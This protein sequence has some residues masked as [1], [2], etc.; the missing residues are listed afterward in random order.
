[1]DKLCENKILTS[2]YKRNNLKNEKWWTEILEKIESQ[3]HCSLEK[4]MDLLA[5]V[6][7]FELYMSVL[8]IFHIRDK[9]PSDTD[10]TTKRKQLKCI[11]FADSNQ[12]NA[13]STRKSDLKM[14]LAT[15][16][17]V[18]AYTNFFNSP[19]D[20]VRAFWQRETQTATNPKAFIEKLAL[21]YVNLINFIRES[22]EDE[23]DTHQSVKEL[24]GSGSILN[25]KT[26]VKVELKELASVPHKVADARMVSDKSKNILLH[27]ELLRDYVASKKKKRFVAFGKRLPPELQPKF[28]PKNIYKNWM[29]TEVPQRL[30]SMETIWKDIT[31]LRATKSFCE[32]LLINYSDVTPPQYLVKCGMM[33]PKIFMDSLDCYL[34]ETSVMQK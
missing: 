9:L 22:D 12:P 1:M 18:N 30:E 23:I 3:K 34:S 7:P 17:Q 29:N 8:K 26:T 16:H 20:K 14:K 24:L 19:P 15:A 25:I 33:D 4:R 27:T 32:F 28:V 11:S 2:K 5:E 6:L 21:N 13:R 10:Q 31:H